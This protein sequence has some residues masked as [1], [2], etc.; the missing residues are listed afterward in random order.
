MYQIVEKEFL[1]PNMIYIKVKAPGIARAALPGQFVMIR[2]DETGER[3]PMSLAG[4]D[5]DAGTIDITFYVIG[6]STMKLATLGEGDYIQN[7]VGPLGIPSEINNYGCVICAC[8]CFG[9]GPTLML[10]EALKE[11][12]NRVITIVEGRG[13]DFVFW[14]DRLKEVSYETHV[15][16]GDGCCEGGRWSEDLIRSYLERKEE[17]NRIYA[18]GCPFMMMECSRASRPFGVKTI[19]S[20]TPLM[21]DGT[22]MC[23]SCRVEVGGE[24]KFA[25]VD[26]PAF[27]GHEVNWELLIHAQRRFIPEEYRSLNLWERE[28]WHKLVYA[29]PQA[30]LIRM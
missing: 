14:V 26:G 5:R 28:N 24:T 18:Y 23:G 6:T 20:L 21:V 8:G 15:V 30:E 13:R 2:V 16:F 9:I 4:L 22:G 19:V 3:I 27:D 7:V 10:A 25:C 17:I 29:Q 12:G 1:V 11:K